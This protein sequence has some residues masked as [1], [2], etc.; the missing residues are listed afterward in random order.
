MIIEINKKE[1][2]KVEELAKNMWSNTKKGFYGK[3]MLNSKKDPFR[4][5]RTGRLGE[6]A[7]S[8]YLQVPINDEFLQFGDET[9][10]V[11]NNLKIDIKTAHK[12]PSY[13]AGLI[14]AMS[15]S[16]KKISLTSDIYVFAYI[17]EEN[18]NTKSAKIKLV[19]WANKIDIE[20]LPL[21]PAK[22]GDHKN[23]EVPYSKLKP[24]TCLTQ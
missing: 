19:G 16:G 22:V 14:R 24:I 9:D 18:K 7:L 20:K 4:V 10:F 2:I 1:Y 17:I 5:E 23:Y 8:K 3:G 12:K 13:E 15:Y 6:M 11:Y 21:Q